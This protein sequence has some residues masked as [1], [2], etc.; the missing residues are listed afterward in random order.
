MAE[1]QGPWFLY[2]LRCADDTLYTGVSPDVPQRVRLHESGR[3]AR[4][5]RGRGPLELVCT[6]AVGSRGDA[7]RAERR[8]KRVRK[9][10]KESLLSDPSSLLAF[11]GDGREAGA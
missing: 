6:V 4:Y 8:F 9:R 11:L 5:V 7:L 1:T 3:G 2:V 10:H